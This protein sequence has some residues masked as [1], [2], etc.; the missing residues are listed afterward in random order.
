LKI[1]FVSSEVAPL[2]KVGGLA[3]VVGSLPRA[4]RSLGHDVRI[5]MPQYDGLDERFPLTPV[6]PGYALSFEPET[7]S[8]NVTT[9]KDVPVYLLENHRYFGTREVYHNDLER[10]YFFSRAVFE[11]L[12]EWD[13]QPDIVHCH[14]WLTALLVLWQK[15][16]G[17]PYKHVFSIHNLAYQG[18]FDANFKY[19]PELTR[20]WDGSPPGT[21]PV[22]FT[23][24][25]Q[26]VLRADLVTTVS[27]TYAREITTP[28]LGVGLD[29][30]LRFRNDSLLG[31]VNGLDQQDWNPQ[32]D[33]LIP[34]NYSAADLHNRRYNK[35]ALQR[36]SGLPVDSQIPLIGMVQRLD[37]QKGL[38]ILG[39]GLDRLLNESNAQIV[40]LGRGQD[41]Y[42]KMLRDVTERY[43]RQ[44]AG[45]VAFEEPLAR[46]I[47][48]GCDIFL[49][50]SRF[51]PCGLGQLIAMRYGAIPV[52]RHTGGLVDTVPAFNAD[53]TRGAGFVFHEYASGTLVDSV[54]QAVSM[55]KNQA[56]WQAAVAR[57]MGLDYSWSVS[58]RL[59]EKAYQRVLNGN[60]H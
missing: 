29:T 23:Y 37:E 11:I 34:L 16:A 20:D 53:L 6:I 35:I 14:D 39:P 51:E 28:E 54:L 60:A 27:P 12:P 42:E 47:Y 45:I 5:L 15:K 30:L 18:F 9:V 43:P 32:I 21:P 44:A 10:F 41:N 24:M 46:L 55:Y 3:D 17:Q 56:L 19:F 7:V 22:P 33:P 26:A 58:A 2:A 25:S 4:L 1:L 8:L 31:I 38:D 52:V 36:V 48:A 50:P 13:F 40:I 57:V 59:Y 49:M